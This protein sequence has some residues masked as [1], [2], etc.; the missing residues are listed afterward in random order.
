MAKKIKMEPVKF[1][2]KLIKLDIA[3]GN[4][5]KLEGFTR[6]DM[7]GEVDIVHDL[8][9]YPWPI[10]ANSVEE[11]RTVGYIQ[12]VEDIISFMNEIYRIL[13]PP[14]EENGIKI[15]GGK[16]LIIAPYQFSTRAWQDP[17]TLRAINEATFLYFNREWRVNNKLEHYP[18]NADFDFSYGYSYTQE[19]NLRSD[20]ART[21]AIK[22]YNN[23]AGDI[24]LVL[25]K[26]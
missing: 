1:E 14:K 3:C 18:I 7:F 21:F 12:K 26:K 4:I 8:D 23:V 19:W 15:H 17:Y 11:A 20:E 2:R 10:E 13:T 9:V 24:Q 16:I 25:T 6:I 22:H 5:D